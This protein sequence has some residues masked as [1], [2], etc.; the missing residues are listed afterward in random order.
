MA[1]VPNRGPCPRCHQLN[2]YTHSLC[3]LCG[4]RLLW[5]DTFANTS[6]EKCPQC[7]HFNTYIKRNCDSCHALLP[8]A[9]APA[10][11]RFAEGNVEEEQKSLALT[12]LACGL[13]VIIVFGFLFYSLA[14]NK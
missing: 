7:Q 11:I 9:D 14:P 10:A 12:V 6:G 5:A 2:L 3:D 4:E 13:V 8:W 1:T